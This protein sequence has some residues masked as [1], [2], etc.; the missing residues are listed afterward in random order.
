MDIF[1][2]YGHAILSVA[3]MAISAQVL[4]ALTG[5]RKNA[6]GMTPGQWMPSDFR[7]PS[8]RLERTYMNSVETLPFTAALIF[9]AILAG[10]S[11]FWVNLLATFLLLSR[12]VQNYVYLKGLG[13]PYNGLRT[14]LAGVTAILNFGLL[15][16]AAGGVFGA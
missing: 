7:D 12:L 14:R 4:N 11:P 6:K 2:A 9:A 13:K 15:I 3:L 16:V 10:G 5:I 8:Y 1:G